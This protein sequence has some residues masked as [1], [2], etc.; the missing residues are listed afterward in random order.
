MASND[1]TNDAQLSG[2][3]QV[4]GDARVSPFFDQIIRN[5]NKPLLD[6]TA[7]FG[8]QVGRF[9][10][11]IG[12]QR[13]FNWG[14]FRKAVNSYAGESL[15]GDIYK[16]TPIQSKKRSVASIA[17]EIA[18]IIRAG[19]EDALSSTANGKATDWLD[20]K[21]GSGRTSWEYR[22]LLAIPEGDAE[23]K[24]RAFVTTIK[25]EADLDE[26]SWLTLVNDSTHN[27]SA[28]IDVLNIVV[29][30]SFSDKNPLQRSAE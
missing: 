8:A 16:Q 25:L 30:K 17:A 27:F 20:F 18:D 3:A 7:I 26:A 19:H 11:A 4:L 6:V 14:V 10:H 22:L 12:P 21:D 9:V 13:F 5:L 23:E 1:A 29:L 28:T 2:E 15:S 24:F